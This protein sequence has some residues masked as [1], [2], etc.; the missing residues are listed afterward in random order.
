MRNESSSAS[1][2]AVNAVASSS[3]VK[4]PTTRSTSYASEMS[5]MSP[6]S[7]PLCT[8][9]TKLPAPPGPTYVT[10]GPR[11]SGLGHLGGPPPRCRRMRRGRR[12]ASSRVRCARPPRRPRRPSPGTAGPSPPLPSAG[13]RCSAYHVVAAVDDD[14][15]GLHVL[16]QAG[17]GG[18]HG[19]ARLDQDDRRARFD[20]LTSNSFMSLYPAKFSPRPSFSARATALSV[21]SEERLYTEILRPSP[22]RSGPG[23]D[24]TRGGACV[25][26]GGGEPGLGGLREVPLLQRGNAAVARRRA[27]RR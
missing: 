18:V 1:F 11:P 2:H 8:I 17:D 16:A 10:H 26:G 25:S 27:C 20:M 14:V 23:S 9:L 7:M 24:R 3:L 19:R 12:R 21:L 6:Y 4:P 22:R 13:A 15:A 5:C